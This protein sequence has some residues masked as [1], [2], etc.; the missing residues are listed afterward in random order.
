M[1]IVFRIA[2]KGG[3]DEA[4]LRHG[5]VG[6]AGVLAHFIEA[7]DGVEMEGMVPKFFEEQGLGESVVED[8]PRDAFVLEAVVDGVLWLMEGGDVGMIEAVGHGDV[9]V[10]GGAVDEEAVGPGGAGERTE[11]AVADGEVFGEGVQD[12]QEVQRVIA[13]DGWVIGWGGA[14]D[15]GVVVNEAAHVVGDLEEDVALLVERAGIELALSVGELL[16]GDVGMGVGVSV[17]GAAGGDAIEIGN[18]LLEVAQHVVE[19]T[20]LKHEDDDVFDWVWRHG[21]HRISGDGNRHLKTLGMDEDVSMNVE[22]ESCH[23]NKERGYGLS[24]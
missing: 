5:V 19:G 21:K 2:T 9:S 15:G 24:F 20:I 22:A 18:E 16:I 17:R 13:H 10:A 7:L 1:L 4:V 6:A 3:L 8:A 11:P 12:G 14:G 23:K